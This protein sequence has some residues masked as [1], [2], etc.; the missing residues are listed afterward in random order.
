MTRVLWHLKINQI[1][2]GCT[3]GC[4]KVFFDPKKSNKCAAACVCVD[5]ATFGEGGGERVCVCACAYVNVCVC[6]RAYV[7]VC[8]FVRMCEGI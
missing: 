4:V 1:V 3:D 2:I 6:V 8:V 5:G 7:C